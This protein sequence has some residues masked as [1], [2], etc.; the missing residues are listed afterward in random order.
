SAPADTPAS[1]TAP[2][3]PSTPL[4]VK[5]DAAQQA[6]ILGGAQIEDV[7]MGAEDED[8]DLAMALAMSKGDDV[9]MGDAGEDDEDAEIARAIAMSMKEA[10]END[11]K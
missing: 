5:K 6:A 2:V 3:V 11:G 1:V 9:E 10:E 4:P 7:G 8:E